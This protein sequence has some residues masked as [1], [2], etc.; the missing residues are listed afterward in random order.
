VVA[1]AL[2][3]GIGVR[4]ITHLLDESRPERSLASISPDDEGEISVD[5]RRAVVGFAWL[6]GLVVTVTLLG[7][8]LGIGVFVTLFTGRYEGYRRGLLVGSGTVLFVAIL[9]VGLLDLPTFEPY[10]MRLLELG[11]QQLGG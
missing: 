4:I 3:I 6:A 10:A 7:L 8:L 1:V 9:F 2:L 5:A 11:G